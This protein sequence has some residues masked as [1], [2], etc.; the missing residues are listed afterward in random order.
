VTARGMKQRLGSERGQAFVEFVIVLPL[1]FGVVFLI[2]WAGVAV[3]RYVQVTDA[4]RD[5]VR[6]AVVARF[7]PNPLTNDPCQKATI[8]ANNAD[9]TPGPGG[10]SITVDC[11]TY[12]GPGQPYTVT[13]THHY[14]M[15]L[16]S[17]F[18]APSFDIT[19]K[20]T[21]RIE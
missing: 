14:N 12:D 13:V 1:L 20:A 2:A 5:G 21:A 10:L 6:A 8:A 4:A 17:I 9:G 15:Q 7:D 3:V 19:S 16:F 18:P 11:S